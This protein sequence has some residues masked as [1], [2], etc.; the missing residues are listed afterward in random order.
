MNF[1]LAPNAMKGALTAQQ[2]SIVLQ[3]TLRRKYPSSEIVSAPVADGGN[4]TLECLMNALGGTVYNTTVTGPV[5]T[6][7]VN[8]RYGITPQKIG[9]I[10]SADAIGLHH[11]TPS[12]ESIAQSTSRGI[13]ELILATQRHQCSEIRIGLGGTATNDGGAGAAAALG[14]ELFD[15]HDEPLK[16]GSI[17]LLQLHTIVDRKAN[18]AVP[19]ILLLTDVQNPLLGDNGATYTYARQK[20]ATEEQLPY[21]EAAL[22]NFADAVETHTGKECRNISGAGAAGGLGFGLLTLC[23]ASVT[24]GIDAVLDTI[25]FDD[26]LAACDCVLTAEG[27]LDE[28]TLFGKGIA[29]IALRAQRLNKPV[30]AFVGKVR[31]DAD[32]LCRQLGLAS[33]TQISPD[34]LPPV[35]AM[36]DASWLLA[37]A[38]YHHTF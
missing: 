18:A 19:P 9:I 5:P 22:K 31:G 11:I 25:G 23:N 13:G 26:K 35:Q 16:E 17:P 36:R 27:M 12:P 7:T 28:Q 20:G 14:F 2:I 32:R 33:L 29:G 8:A 6:M 1:L 10:E 15:E 4:G 37:D 3:R 21:L 38:V 30:H 24:G 34:T